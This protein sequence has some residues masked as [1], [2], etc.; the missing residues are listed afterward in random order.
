MSHSRFNEHL[1]GDAL[2]IMLSLH[3]EDKLTDCQ[4]MQL[5]KTLAT[6][7]SA[8]DFYVEFIT[9]HAHLEQIYVDQFSY[10]KN[11]KRSDQ[12]IIHQ[13]LTVRRSPSKKWR[14]AVLGIPAAL[15]T[16][17]M[18]VTFGIWLGMG[19]FQKQPPAI[20][21][22]QT[23][24]LDNK[25]SN[26]QNQ[27]EQTVTKGSVEFSLPT[28]VKIFLAA[29]ATFRVTGKNSIDLQEGLLT[30]IVPETG[31]GFTVNTPRGRIVDLGTIFGVEVDA[32]GTSSVQV[33]K[34]RVELFDS[35]GIKTLLAAGKTMQSVAGKEEWK[36]SEKLSD[37]F[38]TVLK[39][40]SS[41]I[42]SFDEP[43]GW[44]GGPEISTEVLYVMYSATPLRERFG[45]FTQDKQ[46]WACCTNHFAIVRFDKTAKKWVFHANEFPIDFTPVA[47]DLIIA[48][49][50]FKK[51]DIDIKG[52]RQVTFYQEN[53][54]II[55]GIAH[56]YQASDINI[57]P[58]WTPN[59]E[60]DIKNFADYTLK[61]TYFIRKKK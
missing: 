51:S 60:G 22:Q 10:E 29:P 36:P 39:K 49:T 55:H 20:N 11:E 8:R 9:T 45:S 12:E 61:G 1:E 3:L 33:F 18:L 43:K 2:G 57:R 31:V 19:F 6:D 14:W 23:N 50:D 40:Q 5:Q 38:Y 47:T 53:Y 37:K 21:R 35:S 32:S 4:F 15:L 46:V 42:V 52:K 59:K 30:A 17:I 48:R 34:G 56:G 54:G 41:N 28:G 16:M 26:K 7:E 58:D 13:L 44:L 24:L 27:N 25:N